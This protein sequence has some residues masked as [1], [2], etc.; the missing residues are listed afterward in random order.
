MQKSQIKGKSSKNH[1]KQDSTNQNVDDVTRK[2]K[3]GSA[4]KKTPTSSKQKAKEI[5]KKRKEVE[6]AEASLTTK[7]ESQAKVNAES[8]V[9]SSSEK[10]GGNINKGTILV[11][12][13]VEKDFGGKLYRGEVI[14]YKMFYKVKYEDGDSEDLTW[15]ELESILLSEE[16]GIVQSKNDE[17]QHGTKRGSV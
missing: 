15:K 2:L 9:P 10:R 8:S 6:T 12:R 7:S 14:G 13:K 3:Y 16:D 4:T 17:K 1:V 11:G 5:P